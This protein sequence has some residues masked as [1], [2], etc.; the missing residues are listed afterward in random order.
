MAGSIGE[1]VL[2][3]YLCTVDFHV[4]GGILALGTSPFGER[5]IG[6]VTGGS[7]AGPRLSGMVLPGG[8]NWSVAG[9][10]DDDRSVGTMDARAIWQTDDGALIHVSYGG[11]S[12]IPD[13]VRAEFADPARAG[14][15]DPG[16]YYLRIAPVF[17]T[18]HPGYAWLNG[19]LAIGVGERTDQGARHRLYAVR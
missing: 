16:R 1:T 17:E 10:L 11:R 3:D 14:A 8:G 9:R 5:R 7:F 4:A 12:V 2:G 15:V 13:D 6:Y 19:I 18:A